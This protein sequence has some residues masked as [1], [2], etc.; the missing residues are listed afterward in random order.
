M[1][2]DIQEIL[3]HLLGT[4]YGSQHAP[5]PHNRIRSYFLRVTSQARITRDG[6]VLAE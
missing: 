5:S 3:L 1:F 4:L 2:I 6:G